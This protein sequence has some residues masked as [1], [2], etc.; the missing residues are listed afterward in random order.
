LEPEDGTVSHT[1][2]IYEAAEADPATDRITTRH[3]DHI[4]TVVA[5]G[6]AGPKSLAGLATDW[7][8]RAPT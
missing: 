7:S 8:T 4:T 3:G 5:T 6:D 2:I 1:A